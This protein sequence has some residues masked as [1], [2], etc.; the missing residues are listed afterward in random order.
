MIAIARRRSTEWDNV[1]YV[2]AGAEELPFAD[3]SFDRVWT[4]HA[5]HHW[6]DRDAGI[7]ECFRVLRPG[8]RLMIIESETKGGHGLSRDAADSLATDLV[9]RGF[10]EAVVSKPHRQLIVTATRG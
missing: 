5:F 9:D 1:E 2:V 3:A 8:G 4:I 10:A 7:G 6:E